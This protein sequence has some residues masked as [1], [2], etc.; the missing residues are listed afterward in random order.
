MLVKQHQK[1]ITNRIKVAFI[2]PCL[3]LGGADA[4]M[5]GL[6]KYAHHLEFTGIAVSGELQLDHV[7]WFEKCM[8]WSVPVHQQRMKQTFPGINYHESWGHAVYNAVKD[9]NIIITWSQPNI[10]EALGSVD[11]PVIEYA[12]NSDEGAKAI[13]ASN[14][15]S[16]HYHAACSKAARRSFEG[17]DQIKV[18]YN[19]IDP[20]RVAPRKGRD[21]QR[22]VWGIKPEQKLLLFMGRLV[23]EKHPHAVLQALTKLPEDW[24]GVF[25]GEG[26]EQPSLFNDAKRFVPNRTC[27]VRP[28]Y[29]VGDIL[30]AADCFMLPSDFEGHPL[31]LMEAMLAGVPTVYTD[32][33]VM[34]ELHELFGP[35]GT[36]VPRCSE[37]DIYATAVLEATAETEDALIKV[38]TAREAVWQNFTLPT[39]A[40]EWEQFVEWCLFDFYRKRRFSTIYPARN[41]S[42]M[43]HAE[44]RNGM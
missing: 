43:Q 4:L 7:R 29:H 11:L 41:E 39:I 19:G 21:L 13:C 26:T 27:F 1:L 8:H 12:Q 16:V 14:V 38:N 30:A 35:I 22:K 3:G 40:N 34:T 5:Q 33:E 28:E 44:I 24:C 17:E 10:H 32:F 2:A 20:G 23:K 15:G 6:I 9:A 31:S 37:S 36:M 42:P 25:V 18:I